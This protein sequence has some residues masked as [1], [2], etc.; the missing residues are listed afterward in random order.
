MRYGSTE[1]PYMESKGEAVFS[2]CGRY[3]YSLSR[4]VSLTINSVCLFIMLNPSMADAS[5]DD[6]TVRRCIRFARRWNHG[7]LRIVNL[8]GLIATDPRQLESS[9]D[10]VGP[11]NDAALVDALSAADTVVAAWGSRGELEQRSRQVLG[12]I[13]RLGIRVWHLGVNKT[14]EPRHPLYVPSRTQPAPFIRDVRV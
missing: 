13:D 1:S 6:P 10:P 8:F 2:V 4:R 12:L 3:R 9:D 14:G 11:D 5:V 7:E